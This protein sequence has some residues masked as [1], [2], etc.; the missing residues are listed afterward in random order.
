[1]VGLF[2]FAGC[3]I[4]ALACLMDWRK[5]IFFCVLV[6]FFQ[7][8]FRKLI[9]GE[10]VWLSAVVALFF[11]FIFICA[12]MQGERFSLKNISAWN[13][14]LRIP[15]R[16]FILW[17]VL[18]SFAAFLATH[19]IRVAGIG[20]LAYL[21]PAPA[22]L[23]AYYFGK[24]ERDVLNFVKFYL[25][26]AVVMLSGIY[27]SYLGY[28]WEVL[29]QIGYGVTA[30]APTGE[31]LKLF[32]GFLRTPE[33]AAWHAG[34]AVCFTVFLF[35]SRR[36]TAAFNWLS[37]FLILFLMSAIILTG[38]RKMLV[39]IVLFITIFG[40]FLAYF[41][42]GAVK[43]SIFLLI[44]GA[45][46]A[47]AGNKYLVS[48]EGTTMT[49]FSP[50]YMRGVSVR[51]DAPERFY[52]MTIGSF[53]SVIADN[54]YFGSGAGTGSQGVQHFVGNAI[55][56]GAAEGG[57]G[58]ILAELGLPGIALFLWIM[59]ALVRYLW[60]AMKK[61]KDADPT[62]SQLVYAMTSFLIANAI[63]FAAAHQVFGD[64]FILLILGWIL[65][66]TLAVSAFNANRSQSA[67]GP[68][69]G[70]TPSVIGRE[71]KKT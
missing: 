23:L 44:L 58:K 16:F 31:Q 39:E 30:Y 46:I 37:G 67:G 15:V 38:R 32:P 36:R 19:S 70:K 51:Q 61:M 69:S 53:R 68:L 35:V 29:R 22:L 28:D 6:G 3:S 47:F 10:P 7:D 52:N 48:D 13:S 9:E 71:G 1:M 66:F 56:G 25:V 50:Y 5:G 49:R 2:A 42:R 21:S 17:V 54:G 59:V 60:N 20:L 40:F 55:T 8:P 45:S 43:L 11:A 57:L 4:A 33:T 24:D 12:K 14:P 26:I 62:C 34:T 64:P 63:V 65:G 18:Q 27:L 41:K